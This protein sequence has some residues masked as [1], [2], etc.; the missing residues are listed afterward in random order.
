MAP[1]TAPLHVAV[2]P[3]DR[4][5]IAVDDR[6]TLYLEQFGRPDGLPAVF[7]HGG[8]GSGCQRA[9]ARLFDPRVYRAVLFDQ[10]GAGLSRPRLCLVD[11]TTWHLVEDMERIR[12]ALGIER[13]IV[14]GG[15][16]GSTLALA[17]AE[18]HPGRVLGLVLRA[19]FLGT[20]EEARWAF[21][22]AAPTFYPELWRRFV[23]L[24]P[25]GERDD[26]IA[27]YGARL[28]N[29]D[30]RIHVP[31]ARAWRAYEHMLSELQPAHAALPD[32]LSDPHA[33][34]AKDVPRTPYVEWHYIS[35]GCFLEPDQ[36]VRDAGRLAGVPG[37][38]VQGRYDL[39]CPPAGAARLAAAWGNAELWLVEGIGHSVSETGLRARLVA[40]IDELGRRVSPAHGARS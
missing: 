16:W 30:P 8:P 20:V 12:R 13:W 4:R 17:Y 40:A 37:I 23:E 34:A 24:L 22:G 35:R 6:H 28:E 10:R 14:V 32:S 11:N 18:T 26:P 5:R 25:E 3:F 19:V 27:A 39:L 15:S 38:I 31:A 33:A 7:L 2:E 21:A 36:L 1:D 29:P 9:Q